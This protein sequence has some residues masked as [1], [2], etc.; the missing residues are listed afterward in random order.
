MTPGRGDE[1]CATKDESKICLTCPMAAVFCDS[2]KVADISNPSMAKTA[3]AFG[4]YGLLSHGRTD[5]NKLPVAPLLDKVSIGLKMGPPRSFPW[6]V[7]RQQYSARRPRAKG[8]R[9]GRPGSQPDPADRGRGMA[10]PTCGAGVRH[11]PLSSPTLYR[12]PGVHLR[13]G[14]SSHIPPEKRGQMEMAIRNFP[15]N[16]FSSA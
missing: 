8:R 10:C 2:A 1:V 3:F 15:A 5:I 12:G 13:R 16:I 11:P 14:T 4:I 9:P 7:V 6:P